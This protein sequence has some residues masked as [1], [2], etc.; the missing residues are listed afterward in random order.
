MFKKICII[1][2]N[3]TIEATNAELLNGS[4]K[5]NLNMLN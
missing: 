4:E 2:I 3:F 1:D 5:I